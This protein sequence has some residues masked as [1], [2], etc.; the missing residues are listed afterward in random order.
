[1]THTPMATSVICAKTDGYAGQPNDR[2]LRAIADAGFRYVELEAV[3]S[4]H[5]RYVP[6]QL[7]SAGLATVLAEL[8]AHGVTPVSVAGHADLDDPA[9]VAAL[10]RRIDFAVAVGARFVTTGTG[11]TD[12]AAAAERFFALAPDWIAATAARGVTIALESHGGLTGT[13]SAARQTIERLNS[14]WVRVNYDPANVIYFAGLRPEPDLPLIA[15]YVVH[16]HVKDSSGQPE[17]WDFPTPG[18]GTIDFASLFRTLHAV[19]YN[20]PYSVEMEQPGRSVTEQDQALRQAYQ[21]IAAT[22]AAV[23]AES[24]P[25]E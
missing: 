6:E 14:P 1:M 13:G 22:L 25:P 24:Q 15:D 8:R 4:P 21:F 20:G 9:G 5:A 3:V 19:G 2:V 17:V 7:D 11:H 18:Q 16:F 10:R 12:E 23:A